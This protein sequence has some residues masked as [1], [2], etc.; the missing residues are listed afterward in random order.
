MIQHYMSLV[1]EYGIDGKINCKWIY[2]MALIDGE[3]EATYTWSLDDFYMVDK[4]TSKI[5]PDYPLNAMSINKTLNKY[6][7]EITPEERESI[8]HDENHVVEFIINNY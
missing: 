4:L 2:G 1:K 5:H 8:K 3:R 6:F 7:T